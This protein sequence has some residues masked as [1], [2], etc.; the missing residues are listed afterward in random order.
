MFENRGVMRYTD[1]LLLS[2]NDLENME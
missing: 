1:D 2:H